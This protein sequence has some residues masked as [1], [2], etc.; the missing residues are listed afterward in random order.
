MTDEKDLLRVAEQDT[1]IN[2]TEEEKVTGKYQKGEFTTQGIKIIIE[3]PVG[4]TRNGVDENGRVWSIEMSNTYGYIDSTIGSDGD[5]ID[6]F[7][8]PKIGEDYDVYIIF[9]VD[10]KTGVFDEHKIMLGFES[11]GSAS[12]SY[13]DNYSEGWKGLGSIVTMPI[14]D[15]KDWLKNKSVINENKEVMVDTGKEPVIKVIKL[16]GEVIE[17][18]TLVNLQ[19]QAGDLSKIDVLTVEIASPGGSVYEGLKI[20]IWL[21]SLSE[22]GKMIVTLVTANAYSIASLI[23]LAANHKLISRTAD[24]MVHNPMVPEISHA[25]ANEL[26]SHVVKLRELESVMY[27]LY[28]TFTGLSP[29]QIKLLMDNETYLNADKAVEYGFADEIVNLKER[30]KSMAT[31]KHKI[32]N[33][34]KTLNVLNRVIAQV[35]GQKFVNQLYYDS[36]GGE[37]EIYQ[38]DPATYATGDKTNL[39]EG[40]IT[41]SDGSVVTI[42]EYVITDIVRVTPTAEVPVT[43]ETPVEA[44]PATEET[45]AATEEVPVVTEVPKVEEEKPVAEFN[46]GPAPKVEEE[47]PVAEVPVVE[48]PVVTEEEKPVA[49]VTAIDPTD[50]A[51]VAIWA[52]IEELKTICSPD[53]VEQVEALNRFE[54]VATEAIQAIADNTSSS[55]KPDALHVAGEAPSGSIFRQALAKKEATRKEN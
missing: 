30:P 54:Q 55:F 50:P 33:M 44:V 39:K 14:A 38:N 46:E 32:K 41:L 19:K 36:T 52:A 11:S 51:I 24:V 20:M 43:G 2:P 48:A 53:M 1:N 7:L 31:N 27:E 13:L 9:Q 8:G 45:P 4:S 35:T 10:S 37:V 26:E 29:E 34:S 16:E 18:K 3:N 15:F 6:I 47:K 40:V 25:N 22:E 17:D 5:E 42:A 28:Q 23:M 12:S 49:E 21:N